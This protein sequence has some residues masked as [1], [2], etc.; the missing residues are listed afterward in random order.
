MERFKGIKELYLA[1]FRFPECSWTK[2]G[3][4][5]R[6]TLDAFFNFI[7]TFQS[8]RIEFGSSNDEIEF[9]NAFSASTESNKKDGQFLQL[10]TQYLFP[11]TSYYTSKAEY[12]AG[13]AGTADVLL[14]KATY[15]MNGNREAQASILINCL[16]RVNGKSEK[17]T[18]DVGVG[19]EQIGKHLNAILGRQDTQNMRQLI[20]LGGKLQENTA[21]FTPVSRTQKNSPTAT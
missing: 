8:S 17:I 20:I 3:T 1:E 9:L 10:Y 15:A 5:G 6:G 7:S 19:E 12:C 14:I 11:R 2:T 18:V 4:F 16:S 21:S 13:I